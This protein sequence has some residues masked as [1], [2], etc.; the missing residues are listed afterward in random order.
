MSTHFALTAVLLSAAIASKEGCAGPGCN[1]TFP[2]E[3]SSSLR[4][5]GSLV[6]GRADHNTS[7]ATW[8]LLQR[9]MEETGCCCHTHT[10]Q[11]LWNKWTTGCCTCES[12]AAH[13]PTC[14]EYCGSNPPSSMKPEADGN[15]PSTGGVC[16]PPSQ[17]KC[18]F[19]TCCGGDLSEFFCTSP[20]CNTSSSMKSKCKDVCVDKHPGPGARWSLNFCWNHKCPY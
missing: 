6:A 12:C 14:A 5:A 11:R 2:A 10:E 19:K 15:V 3:H 20:G 13:N 9:E 18:H 7:S 1:T 4:G 8:A 16:C 17:Y